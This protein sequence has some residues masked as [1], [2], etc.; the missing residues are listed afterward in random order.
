MRPDDPSR[1]SSKPAPELSAGRAPMAPPASLEDF[2][3]GHGGRLL[4][5][6][7]LYCGDPELARDLAQDALVRLCR[8][9]ERVQR[10][11]H[12]A[13]WLL[14]VAINLANSRFRR[15]AAERRALARHGTGDGF[16]DETADVAEREEVRAALGKLRRRRREALVLRFYLGWSLEEVAAQM[17]CSRNAASSLTSR[18]LADL[19]TALG[20]DL[21]DA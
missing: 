20:R 3:A 4:G 13:G 8:D 16:S 6:L 5:T 18:A 15:V 19:R 14:R 7:T 12:P 2:V 21:T 10:L 11:D 17:N 9:W 1:P